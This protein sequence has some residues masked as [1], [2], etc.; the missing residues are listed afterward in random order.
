MDGE[1]HVLCIACFFYHS[2]IVRRNVAERFKPDTSRM[3]VILLL[4]DCKPFE[5]VE[6]L[7]CWYIGIEL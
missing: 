2:A 6:E 7:I 4:S 1:A 3:P 5:Y